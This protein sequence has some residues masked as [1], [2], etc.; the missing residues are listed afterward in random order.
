MKIALENGWTLNLRVG[1]ILWLLVVTAVS[2]HY[3]GWLVVVPIILSTFD[4]EE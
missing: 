3:L 1:R 2:I 4:L